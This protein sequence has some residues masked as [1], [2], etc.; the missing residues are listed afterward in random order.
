MA[1]SEGD[2]RSE[3]EDRKINEEY[4]IWKKNTPF[5]YD[6][7]MTHPLE[8]PSLTVEWLPDLEEPAGKDY[9]IQKLIL[10]THTSVG[11]PNYLMIAKVH[12]PVKDAEIA[13]PQYDDSRPDLGGFGCTNGKVQV[14]QKINHDGEVNRAR[15]MPQNPF[16]IAS[17]TI[18]AEVHVFDYRIH[19]CESDP[20]SEREKECKPDL[21]LKGHTAEGFGLSWS[22]FK[23]GYLLSGSDDSRICLWDVHATPRNKTL[24]AMQIF[25]IHK[26][27]V[28]DVAWHLKH[29]YLFGSVG[30]D[31]Y[32]H[33]FDLRSPTFTKPIQTL[34]AH[35]NEVMSLSFNPFNE[36]K[37]ATGSTD[38]TVKLFDLRK[39]TTALHT[40]SQED[41]V[42]QVAWSPKKESV[43]A[44]SCLNRRLMI[45]DI[46][47]IGEE[48]VPEDVKDGPPE[49][50]FIHGGHT[51]KVSEF[52][53]NSNEEWVIAGVAEDNI[54]QIWKMAENIYHD[55]E[56]DWADIPEDQ[57]G[58]S[59][60]KKNK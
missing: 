39:L 60:N 9:S 56:D 34:M 45:W 51:S 3:A 54:L 2:M 36:W 46:S 43:L 38:K 47:R 17:K 22:K 33:I 53:W 1:T 35:Q 29:E 19:P 21:R 6:L 48:Q 40:F 59:Q 18:N 4:K 55:E 12:L 57:P 10:G 7:V 23:K 11:E 26:G 49:L 24:D 32:L 50:L 8:W 5:L 27:V 37:L 25:K 41:E 31:K 13:V 15:Y 14:I 44:S 58:P 28:E 30:D 52:S 20:P 16:V 42:I